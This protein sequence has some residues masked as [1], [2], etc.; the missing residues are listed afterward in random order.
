MEPGLEVTQKNISRINVSYNEHVNAT[1]LARK[2]IKTSLEPV[3]ELE[4]SGILKG[5]RVV[6]HGGTI[7]KPEKPKDYDIL[8]IYDSFQPDESIKL[9][10]EAQDLFSQIY[11][12]KQLNENVGMEV[13]IDDVLKKENRISPEFVDLWL[14]SKSNFIHELNKTAEQ[15]R[16]EAFIHLSELPDMIVNSYPGYDSYSYTEEL[17]ERDRSSAILYVLILGKIFKHKF[18]LTEIE[19]MCGFNPDHTAFG[20]TMQIQNLEKE[21]KKRQILINKRADEFIHSNLSLIQEVCP[22]TLG[23]DLKKFAD[24]KLPEENRLEFSTKFSNTLLESLNY[25]ERPYIK[26][27]TRWIYE[28]ILRGLNPD[29]SIAQTGLLIYG[30]NMEK[31]GEQ[32]FREDK[33]FIHLS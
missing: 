16:D 20:K 30:E 9:S 19:E 21:S 3:M 6:F 10:A 1:E 2:V 11:P 31:G 5:V 33:N 28:S 26:G 18:T 25:Y 8:V 7:S 32:I 22:P 23:E 17:E 12:K 13:T 4:K 27:R 24:G 29:M 15:V 14:V